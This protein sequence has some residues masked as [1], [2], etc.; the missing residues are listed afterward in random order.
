[1][2]TR[3]QIKAARALLGWTA[4]ELATRANVGVATIRRLEGK[5][6]SIQNLTLAKYGGILETLQR[7]DIAFLNED[8]GRVGVYIETPLPQHMEAG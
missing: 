3:E 7:A 1:M 8:G 2:V 4:E 5:D 6:G